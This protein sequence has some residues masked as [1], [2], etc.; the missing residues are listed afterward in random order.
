MAGA[1]E[2]F[3]GL[4]LSED[5]RSFK[6]D[7]A[8]E[9]MDDEDDDEDDEISHFLF[10]KQAVLGVKAK[11][12]ERNVI[13]VE[14]INFDG[15]TITMPIFSL[16]AGLNESIT[17]DVGLQPPVT[18]KLAHGSGPVCLSGQ[19]AIDLEDH[20]D[21]GKEDEYEFEEEEEEETVKK[22]ST[23]GKDKK[24]A[25][26]KDV[27]VPKKGKGDELD[28]DDDDDEEEDDD[29][30]EEEE[31]EEE[32]KQTAKGK[33]RPAPSTKGPAKKMSKPAF[34]DEDDDD[35]EDDEDDDDDE[36]ALDW[37]VDKDGRSKRKVTNGSI[38]NGHA[39]D[40]E[41]DD[42]EED[43]DY[44]VKGEDD[45]DEEVTSGEEE[46]DDEEEDEEVY[47]LQRQM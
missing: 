26:I 18:F 19:H 47:I 43:E 46:E 15:E 44:E 14:T 8:A 21:F 20:D 24:K 11:D 27:K 34:D 10:L 16:R 1:K 12:N 39:D 9:Y 17:L 38:E 28:E 32:E 42:D 29:E 45:D 2:Y 33:K 3:W 5:E 25:V 4:T 41:D 30:D 6:W 13:E 35:D 40:D 22:A 31:E 7:P 23:K 37:K 36:D